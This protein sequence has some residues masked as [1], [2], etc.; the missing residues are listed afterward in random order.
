MKIIA[1]LHIHGR[2]SRGCSK[3]LDIANLEKYARIKGVSLLGTGDFT[4]P[5]W[6]KE[7]RSNLKEEEGILKT[8]SGFSFMLQTEI[9]LV[10]SQDNKGRRV[11]NVVLAPSIEVAEQITDALKKRGR[12]DY[13]GRPI[14]HITCPEFVE[15]MMQI[16]KDIEV[17][18]AH[19]WTPWF[20]LFG[21][22]SG[23]D[24][25]KECFQ[26]QTRNIH[27][28]ETGLSSDP[29]MNWRLSQLDDY[30]MVSFSDLHS[31]WPWRIG[32][33]ATIFETDLTYKKIINAIRT[34]EGIKMTIEVDPAYGKYHEDGHRACNICMTPEESKKHN[35]ICPVCRKPLIIG[36]HHRIEELADRP[37]G[38]KPKGAIPFKRIIPLSEILAGV[39]KKGIATKSIWAEYHTILKLGSEMDILLAT[40]Y[41]ELARSTDERIAKEIINNRKGNIKINP[42]Y[43]GEYGYPIF[44]G[45][46]NACQVKK[47]KKSKIIEEDISIQKQSSNK[48]Q[49][50][51]DEF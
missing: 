19:I 33:E 10:Y 37:Q 4:H 26:D 32:R 35:N 8:R 1:D 12:V 42:G 45:I 2:H 47:D 25:V 9:S 3:D 36:V 14:F 5:G 29:G 51:L 46:D 27:A 6:I 40:P 13:D 24:S 31:Y 15:M 7:I 39:M 11:H 23:F 18:P 38:F 16:S 34:K 30:A 21:S 28:L 43:D 48:K 22:K 44:E 41:E 17:I 20:S 49:K 50:S